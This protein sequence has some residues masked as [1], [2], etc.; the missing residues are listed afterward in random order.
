[1][2]CARAFDIDLAGYLDA[3]RAA[4]FDAFRRHYPRCE[5]CSAEVRA[6]TELAEEMGSLEELS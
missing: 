1:M 5:A 3:P 6:W 2:S 4:E